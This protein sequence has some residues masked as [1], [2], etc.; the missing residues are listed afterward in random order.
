MIQG[1]CCI[2]YSGYNVAK[3]ESDLMAVSNVAFSL[4]TKAEDLFIEI[5]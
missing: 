1:N 3:L 5:K 4:W 2:I